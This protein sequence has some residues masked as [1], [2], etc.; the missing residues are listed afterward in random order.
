M[1]KRS[2]LIEF[3]RNNPNK[4]N[5]EIE[6]AIG[7]KVT[8]VASMTSQLVQLGRLKRVQ[9][10]QT[11]SKVPIYSFSVADAPLVSQEIVVSAQEAPRSKKY[12]SSLDGLVN[13]IAAQIAKSLAVQVKNRLFSELEGMLPKAPVDEVAHLIEAVSKPPK[14]PEVS[15]HVTRL[16]KVGIT[17]LTPQQAGLITNE[18]SDTFD[19][20]FWNNAWGGSTDALKAM[21]RSCETVFVH[22]KHASHNHGEILASVGAKVVN[23]GGGMSAMRDALTSYYVEVN[24]GA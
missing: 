1:S 8:S 13:Q 4:T 2:Q 21:G 15:Q 20:N 19:L 22:T 5:R 14:A 7:V 23:V 17:G 11:L 6:A 18:F 16:R 10:N 24:D 12:Q 3:L 9:V